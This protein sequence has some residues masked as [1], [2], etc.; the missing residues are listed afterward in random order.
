MSSTKEKWEVIER[1]KR[2]GVTEHDAMALRRI[3]MQLHTWHEKECGTD[4]GCIERDETTGKAYWLNSTTMTRY[5]VRDMETGAT[6]R[7]QALLQ[8]YPG[9]TPYIQTD[10]RGASLYLLT[11]D[12][13]TG[14]QPID[15]IYSRGIAIY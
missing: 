1:V 12:H 11:P 4:Y 2:L 14:G 3:A 9:L 13:L 7:L 8:R 15:S 5:P 6:K 10:P